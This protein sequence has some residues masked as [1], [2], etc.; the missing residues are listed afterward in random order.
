MDITKVFLLMV[1]VIAWKADNSSITYIVWVRQ[2]LVWYDRNFT[3]RR[4]MEYIGA[5]VGFQYKM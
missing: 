1:S 3:G 5:A 4:I 2:S